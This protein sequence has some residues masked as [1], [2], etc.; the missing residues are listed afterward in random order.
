MPPRHRRSLGLVATLH[1][2]LL[3]DGQFIA[4]D[5]PRRYSCQG[6]FVRDRDPEN[7]FRGHRELFRSPA[8]DCLEGHQA[9][10]IRSFH[11]GG[12]GGGHPTC[13]DASLLTANDLERV[14]RKQVC[15]LQN[16]PV[17]TIFWALKSKF[18]LGSS[19]RAAFFLSLRLP[20]EET[21]CN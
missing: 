6:P 8:A 18:P 3:A 10:H 20:I 15:C 19:S 5:G 1:R 14:P 7:A 17:K 11:A 21:I 9:A 13:Q 12:F 16:N 4:G 2:L